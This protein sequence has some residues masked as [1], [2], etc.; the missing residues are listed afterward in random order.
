MRPVVVVIVGWLV[1]GI[2]SASALHLAAA[3]EV[4]EQYDA[5]LEVDSDGTW[6]WRRAAPEPVH[7]RGAEVH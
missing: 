4:V 6:A 1:P 3:A 7:D 2:W 5:V